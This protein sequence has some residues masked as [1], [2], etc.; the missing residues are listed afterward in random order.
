MFEFRRITA[1]G[2]FLFI[3]AAFLV[4]TVQ[5]Q[6][7]KQS[8]VSASAKTTMMSSVAADNILAG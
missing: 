7:S 6:D 2:I 5:A 8:S 1:G 3:F 4:S